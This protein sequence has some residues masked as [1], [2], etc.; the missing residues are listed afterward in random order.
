M[1]IKERNIEQGFKSSS[2]VSGFA[3]LQ[4]V[5]VFFKNILFK[6]VFGKGSS[7]GTFVTFLCFNQ[8]E[9]LLSKALENAN[10]M[11]GITTEW[12]SIPLQPTR[13]E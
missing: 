3:L 13:G 8:T 6:S 11:T 1:I 12:N 10:K 4:Q 7:L 5:S 2:N 9:Q